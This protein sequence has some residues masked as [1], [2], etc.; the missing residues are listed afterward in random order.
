MAKG[1][2]ARMRSLSSLYTAG[3]TLTQIGLKN[4][5]NVNATLIVSVTRL[6]QVSWNR[7]SKSKSIR[8]HLQ[9]GDESLLRD[10]D[11]A[12]LPHLLPFLL[13]V[14]NLIIA[15]N[16]I[17]AYLIIFIGRLKVITKDE[18][19]KELDRMARQIVEAKGD[20]LKI[21]SI[22]ENGL[23]FS[24]E[25]YAKLANMQPED[26]AKARS[27]LEAPEVLWRNSLP[28]EP[29]VTKRKYIAPILELLAGL[30]GWV[31]IASSVYSII[32]T[33][34][35]LFSTGSW[36]NVL[37]CC[38]VGGISKWLMK[39]LNDHKVRI[40][41]IDELISQGLTREQAQ[42]VWLDRYLAGDA[43]RRS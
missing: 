30:F 38:L 43:A 22:V 9:R 13:L 23:S 39:G 1:R 33:G 8:V 5:G 18:A 6:H 12:E 35:A 16:R 27:L 2:L 26:Y 19:D 3:Q 10:L 20:I 17:T 42:R 28:A 4:R 14:E 7:G 11:A 34:M 29:Q 24:S 37:Y 32:L 31:W 25:E 36:W 41:F 40:I 15:A 21:S